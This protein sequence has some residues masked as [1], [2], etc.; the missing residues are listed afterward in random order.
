M[1]GTVGEDAGWDHVAGG[2]GECLPEVVS[3]AVS[4]GE[5]GP[6][7]DVVLGHEDAGRDAD[8]TVHLGGAPGRHLLLEQGG[9]HLSEH[10]AATMAPMVMA[11]SSKAWGQ[12]EKRV[13][14]A[15]TRCDR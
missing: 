8:L 3:G 5:R 2:V 12:S 13:S 10:Y 11:R 6:D 7:V 1:S 15:R 4:A 9:E 14:A